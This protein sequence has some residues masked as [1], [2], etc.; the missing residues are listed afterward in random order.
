MPTFTDI[1]HEI[2]I[3]NTS[4]LLLTLSKYAKLVYV[5]KSVKQEKECYNVISANI[6]LL[7]KCQYKTKSK[8]SKKE[9]KKVQR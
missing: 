3:F 6:A 1:W 9:S 8:V 5:T 7:R 2:K 4:D